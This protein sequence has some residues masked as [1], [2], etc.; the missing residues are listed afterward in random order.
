M[1]GFIGVVG[2]TFALLELF[3]I[4]IELMGWRKEPAAVRWRRILLHVG[5]WVLII[6]GFFAIVHFGPLRPVH[7]WIR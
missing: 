7:E 4:T 1:S 2:I 5:A 3:A 6:G